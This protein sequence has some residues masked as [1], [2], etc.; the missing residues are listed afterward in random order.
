MSIIIIIFSVSLSLSRCS[1]YFVWSMRCAMQLRPSMSFSNKSMRQFH[2][3]AFGVSI[4]PE[5]TKQRTA[6]FDEECDNHTAQAEESEWDEETKENA[7]NEKKTNNYATKI[8]VLYQLSH[9]TAKYVTGHLVRASLF[10]CAPVYVLFHIKYVSI[11]ENK[12]I[13]FPD[14]KQIY[15]LDVCAVIVVWCRWFGRVFALLLREVEC[16]CTHSQM[17]V[18]VRILL[19]E[20]GTF[21]SLQF[22]GSLGV[23]A[24]YLD[25]YRVAIETQL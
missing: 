10:A 9:N 14:N 11:W 8:Y 2:L 18:Y 20:E 12:L 19:N 25:W 17:E 24:L 5:Q 1:C 16:V 7:T 23:L 15:C 22:Y 21:S 4:L 3:F 6:L 13:L